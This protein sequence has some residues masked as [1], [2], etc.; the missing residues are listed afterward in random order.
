M[1]AGKQDVGGADDAV[2]S[3]LAGAVAVVEEVLGIGVV[4][5][6]DGNFSVPSFSMAFR[7]MTPVVVSSMVPMMSAARSGA[8]VEQGD[9]VGSRR[10]W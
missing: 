7:R 3:G 4:D 1:R 8:S 2:E 9:Q 6:D 5:G 10:P